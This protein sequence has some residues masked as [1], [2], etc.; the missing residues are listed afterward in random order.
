MAEELTNGNITT[1]AGNDLE[2]VT[3]MARRMVCEWGM[4]DE[5]GP[6]TFGKKEEQVF[7]GRDFAQSQDYS[8]GTAVR[9]DQE[10]KRIVTEN[11]DRARKV[12]ETHKDELVRIA[13]ELLIRE[14]LNGEQVKKCFWLDRRYIQRQVSGSEQLPLA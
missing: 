4:S 14:V 7:L 1:G 9:I 6:L 12:L 10:I 8:E 13:E 3:E 2:R 11:Y 5:I